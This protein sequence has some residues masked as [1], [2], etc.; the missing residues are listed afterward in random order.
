MFTPTHTKAHLSLLL[1]SIQSLIPSVPR[2]KGGPGGGAGTAAVGAPVD[3][4]HL[5][6][7]GRGNGFLGR[8]GRLGRSSGR[9]WL[10]RGRLLYGFLGRGDLR[11]GECGVGGMRGEGVV[12]QCEWREVG[13]ATGVCAPGESKGFDGRA[14]PRRNR[15][16]CAT[17]SRVHRDGP[18]AP[19]GSP[20]S[21]RSR[22]TNPHPSAAGRV[23]GVAAMAGGRGRARA[24]PTRGPGAPFGPLSFNA[25]ASHD[26]NTPCPSPPSPPSPAACEWPPPGP[27]EGRRRSRWR[28]RPRRRR[29]RRGR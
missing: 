17:L 1:F 10:F 18:R 29:R 28:A 3:G 7:G 15:R 5:G 20:R 13:G 26:Q 14:P 9:G 22:V 16:M 11:G 8:G 4:R 25:P 2:R 23:G 21:P 19:P 6:R 12:G 24:P 27:P